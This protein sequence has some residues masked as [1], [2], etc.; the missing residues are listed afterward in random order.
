VWSRLLASPLAWFLLA[1]A[2]RLL[3]LFEQSAEAPDF[4]RPQLDEAEMI[5]TADQIRAGRLPHEPWFK[6]PLYP[7]LLAG[8]RTLSADLSLWLM[9]FIQHLLGAGLTVLALRAAPRLFPGGDRRSRWAGPLA[10]ALIAFNGPLVR[11]EHQLV[12]DF[13]VVFLQSALLHGL[14]GVIAEAPQASRR[15]TAGRLLGAGVL[16]GLAWLTRPTLLPVLPLLAGVVMARLPAAQS[17][18][19]RLGLATLLLL[20]PALAV[21]GFAAWNVRHTGLVA[22]QP[23]QGGFNLHAANRPGTHGRYL[24]QSAFVAAPGANPTRALMIAEHRAAHPEAYTDP[25]APIPGPAIHRWY[26]ARAGEDFL[27]DP[28]AG[29]GRLLRKAVYLGSAREIYNLEDYGVQRGLSRVL[30]AL[31]VGFGWIFP[32]ALA[33][34][35]LPGLRRGAPAL[36]WTYT[37]ALG[38]CIAL[39]LVSGRLRMP[40]VFPGA[41]LAAAALS[42]AR[43]LSAPGRVRAGVLA[44]VGA[45]WAWGDWWGVRREDFRAPEYARLSNAAYRD[46]RPAQALDFVA[47]AAAADPDYP[48]LPQL[49]AQAYFMQGRFAEAADAFAAATARIP[50]DPVAPFNLGL[51]HFRQFA[52]PAAALPWFEEAHRRQPDYADAA[53]MRPRALFRLGRWPEALALVARLESHPGTSVY[54]AEC[55]YWQ[56]KIAGEAEALERARHLLSTTTPWGEGRVREI[57]A[58]H[59]ALPGPG[60]SNSAPSL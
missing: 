6:A 40:L 5:A 30:P 19:Q 51:L 54:R 18:H 47:R 29:L 27:A 48:T 33:A 16:A 3:Y 46:G 59:A 25:A 34:L 2:P 13:W 55:A 58:E 31:P 41:L 23:W 21:G 32:C 20:P 11:L 43:A 60:N 49:R 36:V 38:G 8:V 15:A 10:A 45:V 14:L 26:L 39:F 22:T 52:D 24:R 35:A 12:L 37:L 56:A 28:L 4:Y 42:G 53:W 9:R 7:L 44:L 50:Q 17:W 1:L 57:D